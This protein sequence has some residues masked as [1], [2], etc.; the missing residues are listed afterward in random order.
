ML[1]LNKT[2]TDTLFGQTKTEPEET[3]DFQMNEQM[4][5][6]SISPTINVP[7]K[8][9]WFLAKTLFE[10]LDSLFLLKLMKTIVFHLV[11]PAIGGFPTIYRMD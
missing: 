4:E 10:A 11:H 1:L 9:E 5:T 6:I 2:H 3:L 8:G 7:E